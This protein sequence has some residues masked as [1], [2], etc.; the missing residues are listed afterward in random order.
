MVSGHIDGTGRITDI[1]EDSLAIWYTIE[2]SL[3]ILHYIVEKGSIAIDGI[4]PL[5]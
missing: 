1:K 5:Q 4:F 2:T 3:E